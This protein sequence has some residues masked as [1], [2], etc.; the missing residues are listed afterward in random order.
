[1]LPVSRPDGQMN[2]NY[3]PTT[4]PMSG[5]S[6]GRSSPSDL[7]GSGNPRMPFGPSPGSIGSSRP[8]AGSPSH[9]LTSRLYSKRAREIQAQ[10]GIS[11]S[12]WGPPTSGHSTPL[13]EN[14]PES[15][16]QDSFP[17]LIPTT[18]GSMD[19]PGR[20]ARAGT[21]PSRFPPMGTLNE[22]D[23]QQPYL[24]QTSRPTPST[25]PFRPPGVSGIDTSSKVA[26][27][28]GVPNPA[29]LSR[30][31]AGSM[32]QRSNFLGGGGPFGPS[33]FSTNWSTGRERATTLT[34]IRSSE[35]PTSPSHS[36]F[37]RDGLA[38]TDVKTL[39]YLGL[40]ETPQQGMPSL[41]RPSME[42]L[43][44]QQQQQQQA[45]ALPP[46]LAE[47]AMM[48]NN[49]RF[50]S[51]SVN[52]KEK[53]AD[54]ED[55][56]YENR[57]SQLPSGTM[58]P[59]AA[60][61]AA[62]LAATQAQ[63]HQHNL[64][65]QA[66]ASHASVS[67]PRARTAGIL[68]APPQRS[69]IRNYLATPSRLDNSFS[70]ADLQIAENGEYDELSEAVQLMHL[71]GNGIPAMSG[72]PA[73]EMADENNQDGPTRALWIGSIPVSTTVTS[74]EA[75]FGM[76]GKI[77][78]TRVLTHKN[79]GFVNFDR[80]DSAVQAKSLLNG[81]EIFPGAGPVRI[82]YAKVPGA[83]AT[84]T[85]GANGIQS[86][87][88]PEQNFRSNLAA[89]DGTD[90]ADNANVIPQIPA[91][92]DLLPEMVQIVQEFGASEDDLKNITASIQ[93]SIAFKA[94]EDEIP[95][96]QET[97]QSRM[98]DAPR[99][100]DIRKRIDNG[101]CSIQEI[102]ETAEA[103]LPEIAELASD[104][105]GN[106][107]VQKLFEF[108]SESTKEQMLT[109][110]APHL[111]E[112]GV[113]KN[114]TWAAQKIIDVA[115]TPAQMK[116][117]VDALR[118]YT[119]P[120]FLDQYGNYV[121]QCCL[122]FG[123]PFN[124]FI[125]E[126]MLSRMWE[127][128]QGRFGARAMR[129]CLESHHATKDQQRML[130]SAIALHS[131]QLAT[132][133]NGALLLTWFLDTCTFPR[134]R[135]VL[136]PRLVPHLV[137]L[138]THKVAYLT[139]LKVINQRNEPDARDIV[140]KALFFS[141]GDEVLEKILI[142]QTS[143]ATLIFKVL[144][145]P[146]FDESMRTEVV[147]NVSKILTKLKASPSQGYKRLMDE[148]GLS[149][150][151]SGREHHHGREHSTPEKS[152][153]RQ[154]SRHGSTGYPAQPSMDRQYN[155]QF[156]PNTFGQNPDNRPISADQ[157]NPPP[158]DPY[159]TNGLG[160]HLNG[161]AGAGGYSQESLSQQQLQYQAFLAAQA[162]GVP[163]GYPSMSG[164]NYG[165][166]GG[167][168]A[169]DNLR[170]LQPQQAS[171][172]PAGPGQM[173]PN[174][175]LA[176]NNYQQFSPVVNPAQM[177]QYPPQYYSQAQPVQGQPGGGRRGRD[178]N[179]YLLDI[180]HSIALAQ[181]G[182][183][184]PQ[185]APESSSEAEKNTNRKT[186]NLLSCSPIKE[187][188]PS[189]EP[190]KP[191]ALAKVLD[192]IPI[193]ERR[194]HSELIL[195]LVRDSL[196]T[197]KAGFPH[198]R[199]WCEARAVPSEPHDST[200]PNQHSRKRRRG[201]DYTR[202]ESAPDD[203]DSINNEPPIILSTTSPNDFEAL[204]ELAIVKNPSSESAI[205]RVGSWHR[206]ETNSPCEYMV[207][208]ESS[209]V[210]CTLPLFQVEVDRPSISNN[211]PIPGLPHHQ[212][213]NLI[214]MDPPWPNKS[215]RRSRHYQT[216]HYSEMDVLTEGLRDILRVHSHDP[217]AKQ[218]PRPS[219]THLGPAV[220]SEQSIAAIWITN[221][222]KARRSA[223][224]ALGDAGF[225][226]CEE[227]I[228]IKTTWDGQPISALDGLWRKPYE[229]LVIGR[230]SG[231]NLDVNVNANNAPPL[232]QTDDL[233]RMS[234]AI[235]T[236]RVIAAV[237]DLHSRKPNLK[238]VFENVFFTETGHLLEYSALEV[239]ARN[240]T[241]GWWAAGNEVLQ[242]NARECWVDLGCEKDTDM[243]ECA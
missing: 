50:R 5:T 81:K 71:G 154:S 208:P 54:D 177:Y 166:P 209:F 9:D 80:L 162:R 17:D 178:K 86:S 211:Y 173:S 140:L 174:P 205:I 219:E 170:S 199:P 14:I 138:C 4:Q 43:M 200:E 206:D 39:D 148:V 169:V 101:A 137:H 51:Y 210:L 8:G 35:G 176:Q 182:R 130:A 91:L 142:D 234:E 92:A 179:I 110:I 76:Y 11:P 239:F 63:I 131:V 36:S 120:L 45:S 99:L 1:M 228:W 62:Q 229:I 44:Q 224:E 116:L 31:R 114:G 113:H 34:S 30:L 109:H 153:H 223:Y 66:F 13:R 217:K 192:T 61:T 89:A 167:S 85:P 133:A 144:T 221:A 16:S 29:S 96:V 181:E 68:E 175:M 67:R 107:V 180:P 186:L 20:R 198:D 230:K 65:V 75:I 163:T 77:E 126:S 94:F 97:S 12:I 212:K 189:T 78:S 194:F 129:A 105:L 25:S 241:A 124:S 119:V 235:T 151:G 156:T 147:K 220:Q 157:T 64:A 102:E 55:L 2:F 6:T 46:L 108:C 37:S 73:G 28:T 160:N 146:F 143:G 171:P 201:S 165:Y 243:V 3:I 42:A 10:E 168:P 213:F 236:R 240:L 218:R 183:S 238:S 19:S 18:N 82:G 227:W 196:E 215:V 191:A 57:Y 88:T 161:L 225:A 204:S 40:A 242:F 38:D 56:E 237:P 128:A 98:F 83:S 123:S 72:R 159:S 222:E 145:T 59:T 216:H 106:T 79:C 188:F 26:T 27:S 84:G 164:A 117:I 7:A 122:R 231:L 207:P 60:A 172:L 203:H 47:L 15:P 21:V 139:V 233:T 141:P 100:R 185:Q 87:P 195:P 22:M 155:G 69:S 90:R 115:K 70:A 134:R 187:P 232:P 158:L 125:F 214:L 152:Q 95:S 127:V 136:A 33:L 52:A 132:N 49:N 53:Y 184:I 118:P 149:S 197:I 32:P 226:I 41:A 202:L 24:S 93:T 193:S 48:K 121:L 58:T 74:L 111:S 190:K 112:I 23:L 104:Y 135:T 103:M 150:R